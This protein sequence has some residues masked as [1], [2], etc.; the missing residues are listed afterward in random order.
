MQA[1]VKDTVQP[2]QQGYPRANNQR[3]FGNR[4]YNQQ[5]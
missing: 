2:R 5:S 3:R 4:S 1:K